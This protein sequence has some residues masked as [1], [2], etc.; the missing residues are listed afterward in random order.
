[1]VYKNGNHFVEILLNGKK[2]KW[3][4]EDDV[5]EFTYD[6]PENVDLKINNRCNIGCPYCH[7]ASCPNGEV[8]DLKTL[9]DTPTSFIHSLHSGTELAIGGG[10][11]FESKDLIGFLSFLKDK[12]VLSNITVNYR[13]AEQYYKDLL[14][15][16]TKGLVR[17]IGISMPTHTKENSDN[18]INVINALGEN[19]VLHYIVGL[20][21]F[22]ESLLRMNNMKILFLG[23]KDLRR[24]HEYLESPN[25]SNSGLMKDTI[26]ERTKRLKM[27]LPYIG[28]SNMLCFDNLAIEQLDL[29]NTLDIS[30]KEWNYCYQGSDTECVD[31]NGNITAATMY[32]DLPNCM[33]ARMSTAPLEKRRRFDPLNSTIEEIFKLSVKDWS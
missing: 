23:Y 19:V 14:F 29:K 2:R 22:I 10:N 8:Y 15:L 20:Q 4:V 16:K 1:M 30:D 26:K 31:K 24:G 33:A 18:L 27:V 11:I 9:I 5:A 32:I 21:G 28:K 17:G 3:T 13:H 25:M 6:F 12:G 7:E